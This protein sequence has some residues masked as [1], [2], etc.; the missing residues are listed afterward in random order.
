MVSLVERVAGDLLMGHDAMQ[1]ELLLGKLAPHVVGCPF[2]LAKYTWHWDIAGTV[3]DVSASALLGGRF[4][5][6]VA[7]AGSVGWNERTV[8]AAMA[9]A[10]MEH[11]YDHLKLYVGRGTMK[12]DLH[13]LR[14]FADMWPHGQVHDR[15]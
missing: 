2:T 3:L 10:Q 7:L 1:Q 4:R 6:R 5:D 8:M 15:C 14:Q 11:G 13:G 9:L 12:S